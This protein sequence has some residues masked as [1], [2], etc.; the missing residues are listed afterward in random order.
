M[1]LQLGASA[2]PKKRED[3]P[4]LKFNAIIEEI[5]RAFVAKSALE[6]TQPHQCRVDNCVCVIPLIRRFPF[7]GYNKEFGSADTFAEKR[8]YTTEPHSE[9]QRKECMKALFRIR[10]KTLITMS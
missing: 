8:W 7:P 10:V 4:A 1:A 3:A 9:M 6:T 5:V 2:K